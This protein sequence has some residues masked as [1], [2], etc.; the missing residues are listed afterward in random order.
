MNSV[1]F[2]LDSLTGEF[3]V[4]GPFADVAVRPRAARQTDDLNCPKA[5]V[6]QS[7]YGDM[8]RSNGRRNPST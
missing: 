6:P 7:R 4:A 1:T 2:A 8:G 5:D 3:F